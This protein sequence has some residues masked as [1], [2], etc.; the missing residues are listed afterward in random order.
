MEGYQP[1]R[2]VKNSHGFP[3]IV[4]SSW[5]E[6]LE[7]HGNTSFNPFFYGTYL[8][9]TRPGEPVTRNKKQAFQADAVGVMGQ[10]VESHFEKMHTFRLEWQ[11][12]PG[13]RLDWF[14][15]GHKVN[16]TFTMVGDGEGKDWYRAFSIKDKSLKDL[17]GSQIPMEP[18]YLIFNTA[19]SSNWGFPYT[20]PSWCPRCYDCLDPKCRCNFPDGFCQLLEQRDVSMY[21]DSVRIYQ[22]HN[23]SAHVGQNHSLGCDPPQF[24][25]REYIKGNEYQYS[26]G[27]PWSYTDKGSL[28]DVRSG[29]DQCDSALDCGGETRGD[30]IEGIYV[31]KGNKK[32]KF[33]SPSTIT[34]ICKCNDGFTGP[35]CLALDHEDEFPSALVLSK[36]DSAFNHVSSFFVPPF[37]LIT[38]GTLVVMVL[39]AVVFTGRKEGR[40]LN[41][42]SELGYPLSPERSSPL[43][44]LIHNG[45]NRVPGRRVH[46]GEI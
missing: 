30:C 31:D 46:V 7:I 9:E 11:P 29:G 18:S 6:G 45:T 28:V 38:L 10:F 19:I 34:K 4:E 44:P 41:T 39:A 15:Q 43:R 3:T 32:R 27:P 17:M 1:I 12:G 5:Y 21:V 42:Y 8:A 36:G 37:M 25:T 26:R 33:F 22:S 16:E 13:G 23:S 14:M 2:S 20:T 35:Q 24:P 40:Q